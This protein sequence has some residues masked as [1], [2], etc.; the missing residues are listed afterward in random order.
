[1]AT[2]VAP[3]PV[4]RRKFTVDEYHQMAAAGIL[5]EDDRRAARGVRRHSG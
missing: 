1:M 3:A 4:T 5:S 2:R